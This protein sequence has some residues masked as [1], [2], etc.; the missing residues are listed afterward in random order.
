MSTRCSR[1]LKGS[2]QSLSQSSTK[3][4]YYKNIRNTSLGAS[5]KAPTHSLI[6]SGSSSF[7]DRVMILGNV[8]LQKVL[9]GK[10][11]VAFGTAIRVNFSIV[12]IV[13]FVRRERDGCLMRCKRA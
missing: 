7:V 3:Q 9:A 8:K 2:I 13:V 12:D 5:K 11:L 10:I 1:R 4:A 6:T